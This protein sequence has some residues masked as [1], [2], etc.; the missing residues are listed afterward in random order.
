MLKITMTP[1][2]QKVAEEKARE[3]ILRGVLEEDFT[4]PNTPIKLTLIR[5]GSELLAKAN[6]EKGSV[7]GL[8]FKVDEV[9]FLITRPLAA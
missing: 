9:S 2:L 5:E 1:A 6:E 8:S 7:L 4:I 3:M